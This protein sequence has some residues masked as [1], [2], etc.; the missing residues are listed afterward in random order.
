MAA[1]HVI[2]KTTG[3]W[4]LVNHVALASSTR[5]LLTVVSLFILLGGLQLGVSVGFNDPFRDRVSLLINT[6]TGVGQWVVQYGVV[7]V[8]V[9]VIRIREP[10]DCK[11]T[12]VNGPAW[13]ERA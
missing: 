10:I 13:P 3:V 2:V 11:S 5:N 1:V 6:L 12:P 9:Y 8:I 4:S 7:A